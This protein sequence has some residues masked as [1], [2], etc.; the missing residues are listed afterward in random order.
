MSRTIVYSQTFFYFRS[1]IDKYRG[2]DLSDL[3][4]E[5]KQTDSKLPLPSRM[6]I[7]STFRIWCDTSFHENADFTVIWKKIYL[8][9]K[10]GSEILVETR[11]DGE[12]RWPGITDETRS[13]VITWSDGGTIRPTILFTTSFSGL[14][15]GKNFY[16]HFMRVD[17][18]VRSPR[19][20]DFI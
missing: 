13:H 9:R 16:L 5:K 14:L 1:L 19:E 6:I 7:S 2:K 4:W 15:T 18:T 11:I 8:I 3:A 17:F 10:I 20:I 12:D